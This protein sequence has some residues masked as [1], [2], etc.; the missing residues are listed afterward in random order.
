MVVYRDARWQRML[1][2]AP[3]GVV[4][5]S[6]RRLAALGGSWPR[7]D[8]Y[9]IPGTGVARAAPTTCEGR[10]IDAAQVQSDGPIEQDLESDSIP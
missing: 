7:H 3:S 6:H 2:P 9:Q 4:K 8:R 5:V 10:H 1:R